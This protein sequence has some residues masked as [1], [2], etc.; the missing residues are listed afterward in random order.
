MPQ[1]KVVQSKVE[2]VDKLV[3]KKLRMRRIFLGPS[4]QDLAKAANVS[5]QQI[6]KYEKATNRISSGRLYLF[7][8]FLKVPVNYFFGELEANVSSVQKQ[9]DDT[10][11]SDQVSEGEVIKLVKSYVVISEDK[12]RKKFVELVKEVAIDKYTQ[13]K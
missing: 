9:F 1:G 5:I 10:K 12:V 7:A 4:Q 8:K 11:V 2:D 6:Q 13:N 3:S